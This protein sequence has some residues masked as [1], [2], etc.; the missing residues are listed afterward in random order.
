MFKFHNCF[1]ILDEL[2]WKQYKFTFYFQLFNLTMNDF[3]TT[4]VFS[5]KNWINRHITESF[6][7]GNLIQFE[8]IL[9]YSFQKDPIKSSQNVCSKHRCMFQVNTTNTLTF[10]MRSMEYLHAQCY[11]CK[12]IYFDALCSYL[13]NMLNITPRLLHFQSYEWKQVYTM[14]LYV[15]DVFQIMESSVALCS[16]FS[17]ILV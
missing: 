10:Q 1:K 5:L 11:E 7:N 13:F 3:G 15:Y 6:K 14:Y 8:S 4:H 9:I 17:A 2:F 16:I 12:R